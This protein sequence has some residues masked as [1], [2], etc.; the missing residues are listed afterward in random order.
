MIDTAH[1]AESIRVA[2]A[3]SIENTQRDLNIALV[4]SV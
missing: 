1:L 4:N 3:A 2:E